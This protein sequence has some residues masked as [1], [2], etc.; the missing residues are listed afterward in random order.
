MTIS[1][2]EWEAVG[3][4]VLLALVLWTAWGFYR[5]WCSGVLDYGYNRVERALDEKRFRFWFIADVLVS[6]FIILGAIYAASDWIV[7]R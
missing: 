7:S 6:A 5:R 3:Y 1:R 2:S 4:A